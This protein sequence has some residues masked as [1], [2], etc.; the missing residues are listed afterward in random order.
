MEGLGGISGKVIEFARLL[1]QA[2]PPICF[3]VG[4]VFI[5]KG[6]IRY[7]QANS[8]AHGGKGALSYIIT[9]TFIMNAKLV[10][11]V[12]VNTIEAAGIKLPNLPS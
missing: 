8:R 12:I 2:L 7:G 5:I 3:V 9:G 10:I 4:S 1:F 6:L 11:G